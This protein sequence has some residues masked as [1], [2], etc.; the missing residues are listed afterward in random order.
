MELKPKA[1][2]FIKNFNLIA[3]FSNYKEIVAWKQVF[4]VFLCITFYK[5][6]NLQIKVF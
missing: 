6:A 3:N 4:E 5:Q 2:I 1:M